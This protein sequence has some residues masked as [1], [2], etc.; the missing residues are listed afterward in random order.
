MPPEVGY[1]E[2]RRARLA[3][4]IR[5]SHE[6]PYRTRSR[7]TGSAGGVAAY[8]SR[9]SH[10][11]G[12]GK[13]SS[14]QTD[15]AEQLGRGPLAFCQ[16]RSAGPRDLRRA[17]LG[18]QVRQ[19]PRST[20]FWLAGDLR[21]AKCVGSTNS[22]LSRPGRR[23]RD[24]PRSREPNLGERDRCGCRSPRPLSRAESPITTDVYSRPNNRRSWSRG[25]STSTFSAG[26][27]AGEAG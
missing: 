27:G 20:K 26:A 23:N 14:A 6:R 19:E 16:Q 2:D 25:P 9:W 11:A 4:R 8:G 7:S 15:T 1:V 5:G 10:L 22:Q 17:Y 12:R 18:R 3:R 13:L 21:R 24:V